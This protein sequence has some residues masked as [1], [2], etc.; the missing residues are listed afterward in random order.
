MFPSVFIYSQHSIKIGCYTFRQLE[1]AKERRRPDAGERLMKLAGSPAVQSFSSHVTD[2]A[3]QQKVKALITGIKVADVA[4]N[5]HTKIF[6][7]R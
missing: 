6:T 5:T 2:G 4:Q 7:A 3:H 1:K